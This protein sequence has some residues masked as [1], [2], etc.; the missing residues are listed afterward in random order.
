MGR[1]GHLAFSSFR[2]YTLH[3]FMAEYETITIERRGRVAVLTVNRPDKLNALSSE[4]HA[5]G[6]G[7]HRQRNSV[8]RCEGD[9]HVVHFRQ[10]GRI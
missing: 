4:V 3:L 1:L 10:H 6:V 8:F 9:P 7:R 2:F 5:E